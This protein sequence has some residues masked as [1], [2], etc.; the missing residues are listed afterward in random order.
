MFPTLIP[1]G[2]RAGALRAMRAPVY[3]YL[4]AIADLD[5]EITRLKER[6]PERFIDEGPEDPDAQP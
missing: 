6:Y 1:L 3:Q 4:E 5:R 2:E